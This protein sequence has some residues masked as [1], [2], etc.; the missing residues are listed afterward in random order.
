[1][2]YCLSASQNMV[3]IL[4]IPFVPLPIARCVR[5]F[6]TCFASCSLLS[7]HTYERTYLWLI[8]FHRMAAEKYANE[9]TFV[10]NVQHL[11]SWHSTWMKCIYKMDK[12]TADR[13]LEHFP[14]KQPKI[15]KKQ[16]RRRNR[17]GVKLFHVYVSRTPLAY[18]PSPMSIVYIHFISTEPSSTF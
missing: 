13:P 10:C 5:F 6:G 17:F 2:N 14:W 1:M 8:I 3:F 7:E 12:T 15:E 16:Q 9:D 18:L 4:P 11:D